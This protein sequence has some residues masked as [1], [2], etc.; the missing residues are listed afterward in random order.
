[1]SE[2]P[3]DSVIVAA[4]LVKD[5]ETLSHMT[6]ISVSHELVSA[7][8]ALFTKALLHTKGE[9]L[10]PELDGI[11]RKV[12]GMIHELREKTEQLMQELRGQHPSK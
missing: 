4:Q 10:P 8:H 5:W 1:M 9:P 3:S 11:L 12:A 2:A 7:G 6:E